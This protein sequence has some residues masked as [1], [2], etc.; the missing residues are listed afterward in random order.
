MICYDPGKV[1]LLRAQPCHGISLSQGLATCWECW[2]STGRAGIDG[3]SP[4]TGSLAPP[5]CGRG[6][7][8]FSAKNHKNSMKIP[9]TWEGLA[10]YFMLFQE[11]VKALQ[12]LQ[13][14]SPDAALCIPYT[15][16]PWPTGGV[17]NVGSGPNGHGANGTTYP[18]KV[19]GPNLGRN[20]PPL[21]PPMCYTQTGG[22][23]FSMPNHEI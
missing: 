9:A 19:G 5:T 13:V 2:E 12:T 11:E 10:S 4:I 6:L 7:F 20:S 14:G 3:R 17:P 21:E 22:K 8:H 23:H 1:C 18:F 15:Y 16:T